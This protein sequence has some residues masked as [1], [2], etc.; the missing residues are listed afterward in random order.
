MSVRVEKDAIGSVKIPFEAYYGATTQRMVQDFKISG[1]RLHPKFLESYIHIKKA[2]AFANMKL[3]L[4]DEKLGRAIIQAAD[5]I[6]SGKLRD[7]FL[8]DAFQMG[9]GT[10][11]NMNCNEVIANRAN[12]ILGYSR[13]AYTPIHPND[14]VNMSQ[15]TNDTFPTAM[16]IA[17]IMLLKNLETE[18]SSLERSLTDKGSTFDG[19][20]KSGRTHLQDAVPIRLGQEF[21]AYGTAIAKSHKAITLSREACGDLGIGG[22]AVGTGLNTVLGYKEK[23][24]AEL[25]KNT[26]IE[27]R[28]SPDLIEAM[29]SQLVI[30]GVSS[31]LRNLSLELIRIANDIRLLSSGPKTGLAEIRL[32]ALNPGSSIMPGKV[33]PSA[34]ELLNMVCFQVIGND[35]SISMA[36]QAGQLE[37]NVMMPLMA[38]DTLFSIEILTNSVRITREKCIEGIQADEERCKYYSE[39]TLGLATVLND[40]IGYSR[41]SELVN[42]AVKENK[43][44]VEVIKGER[45]FPIEAIEDIFNTSKMTSPS[46]KLRKGA[47]TN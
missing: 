31:S 7:Q 15:S 45:M 34:L 30:A 39:A 44:L 16:R 6:L 19:V 37:L 23:V 38:F 21:R 47:N 46:S 3:G 12:E 41:A 32:P 1:L 40:S 43:T 14:H 27:L 10:S 20:V 9:A 22:T 4:L 42:I 35:L 36:V 18:L 24:V 25:K 33:N 29:Q 17:V 11:F 13:G 28:S 8:V 26:N 5:E 2:C